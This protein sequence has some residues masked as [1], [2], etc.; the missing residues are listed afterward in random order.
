MS[1]TKNIKPTRRFLVSWITQRKVIAA[2][3]ANSPAEAVIKARNDDYAESAVDVEE[4]GFPDDDSY[5]CLGEF[6]QQDDFTTRC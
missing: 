1:N 2:V 5:K 3:Y 6:L 4:Y